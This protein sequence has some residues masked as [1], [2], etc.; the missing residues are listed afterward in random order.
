MGIMNRA[1]ADGK[2]WVAL[3]SPIAFYGRSTIVHPLSL[4]PSVRPGAICNVR[5][6]VAGSGIYYLTG[7][8]IN[9][10]RPPALWT[11]KL[12]CFVFRF[13]SLHK[14]VPAASSTGTLKNEIALAQQTFLIINSLRLPPPRY[15]SRYPDESGLLKSVDRHPLNH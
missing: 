1:A 3:R 11:W 10:V 13:K 4:D 15:P 8:Q 14:V 9:Y 7:L 12:N 6:E 2:R 5:G